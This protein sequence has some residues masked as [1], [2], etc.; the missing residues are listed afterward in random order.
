MPDFDRVG[1]KYFFKNSKIDEDPDTIIFA[2]ME[3]IFELNFI[4]QNIDI[5]HKF[6][7]P[8]LSQPDY[9][10]SNPEQRRF[11][12]ASTDDGIWVD[13]DQDRE[14]DL[15]RLYKIR[16]ILD[17]IYDTETKAFYMLSNRRYGKIGFFLVKF[18]ADEPK[19]YN[20][21]TMI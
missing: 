11:V 12:I 5:I 14:V 3:C 8:L 18:K 2:K 15:D 17:I 1:M 4:T 21:M 13:L 6:D 16:N 9:F 10:V 7:P 20:Y 19:K